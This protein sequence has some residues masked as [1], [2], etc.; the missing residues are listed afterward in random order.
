MVCFREKHIGTKAE[1][2]NLI[3]ERLLLSEI[4]SEDI[5]AIHEMN[6]HRDVAKFNTIGIPESLSVTEKLLQP[7]LMDQQKIPRSQY[8]WVITLKKTTEFVG[9]IGM[10]LSSKKYSKGEIHYSLLPHHWGNGYATEAVKQIIKFGFNTLQLHRITAG[11]A[12]ENTVSI[13]L[14]EKVGMTREG[15]CRK[16]LPLATGWSDNYEY[17]ILE[18]DKRTY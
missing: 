9:E 13:K 3:S 15:H 17:A 10:S 12:I 14:L 4:T 7:I 1:I 2:M 11:V 16:I 5:V 6:C 8:I 18:E